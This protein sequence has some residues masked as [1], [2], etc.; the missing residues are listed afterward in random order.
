MFER[1]A[2]NFDLPIDNNIVSKFV[3]ISKDAPFERFPFYMLFNAVDYDDAL[4]ML[5]EDKQLPSVRADYSKAFFDL[6]NI[7]N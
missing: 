7:M 5:D 1:V 3:D 4:G 2:I 6:T